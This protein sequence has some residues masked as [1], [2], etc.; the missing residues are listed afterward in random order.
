M[1]SRSVAIISTLLIAVL[2]SRAYASDRAPVGAWECA[3]RPGGDTPA[4]ADGTPPQWNYVISADGE[5]AAW[6]GEWALGHMDA[7]TGSLIHGTWHY[8]HETLTMTVTAFLDA[9]FV[10][11]VEVDR[12]RWTGRNSFI[13]SGEGALVGTD[14]YCRGPR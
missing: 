11:S 14:Y 12:I 3:T 6:M 9:E 10:G 4:E 13:M 2:I 1:L 7:E 8:A 5:Y